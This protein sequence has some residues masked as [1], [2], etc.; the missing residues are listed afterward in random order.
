MDS[1]GRPFR[2]A[3]HVA[4]LSFVRAM[5]DDDAA[6][7]CDLV[8]DDAFCAV[9]E[10]KVEGCNHLQKVLTSIKCRVLARLALQEQIFSLG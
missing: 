8:D 4:G 9:K 10:D 2:W 6:L 7:K 5:D 3:Q 1:I